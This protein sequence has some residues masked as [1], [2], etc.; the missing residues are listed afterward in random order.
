MS[1]EMSMTDED[2]GVGLPGSGSE[3]V[4][5]IVLSCE[6]L[7]RSMRVKE[8]SLWTSETLGVTSCCVVKRFQGVMLIQTKGFP[9]W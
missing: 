4:T 7:E 6:P 8:S 2:G 5:L 3:F 1:G 9:C